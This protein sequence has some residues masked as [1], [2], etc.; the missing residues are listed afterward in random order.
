[1]DGSP[2]HKPTLEAAVR[3]GCGAVAALTER[4]ATPQGWRPENGLFPG[5]FSPKDRFIIHERAKEEGRTHTHKH[6]P[7]HN[8]PRGRVGGDTSEST[9][10]GTEAE[11][12]GRCRS[13]A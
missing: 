3:R 6:T 9:Q 2:Q 7:T 8:T 13:Q 10:A 4:T 1:M 5:D 12:W 11:A